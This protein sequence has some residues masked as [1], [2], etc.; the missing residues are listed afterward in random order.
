MQLPFR[1]LLALIFS[2][3]RY[4]CALPPR[5]RPDI[6]RIS[7]DGASKLT[8]FFAL[9]L[10]L[11]ASAT[12]Q[13]RFDF[14]RIYGPSDRDIPTPAHTGKTASDAAAIEKIIGFVKASGVTD[15]KGMT[16]DGTITYAGDEA[17]Y[18]AH[19][20]VLGSGQ[21]RLD[22]DGAGGKA[23]TV[24]NGPHGIS[25]SPQRKAAAVPAATSS[26]GLL[27]FPRLLSPDYPTAKS[28]LTDRGTVEIGGKPLNRI[29]LDEPAASPQAPWTTEDLYFDPATGQLV[30]SAA[31]VRLSTSEAA[32]SMLETGYGNYRTVNG[33]TLPYTCTQSINGQLSWTL[34]LKTLDAQT[35]P[36]PTAFAY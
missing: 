12:A 23:S 10:L 34:T 13:T 36:A 19:L 3:L 17:S 21:Y 31:L 26:L 28:I 14:T 15:W 9:A 32:L 22:V 8:C 5:P 6:T 1:H 18:P 33:V 4:P 2:A 7:C 29:A 20:I 16:A 11:A 25:I 35:V 30:E 24:L 27:A